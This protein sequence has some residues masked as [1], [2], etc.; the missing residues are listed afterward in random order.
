VRYSDDEVAALYDVLNPWGPGDD[1]YLALV[2]E[3]ASVLDVGCGTGAL[4]DRARQAGHSGR[5]VGLDPDPAMLAVAR[6][7]RGDVEWVAGTAAS[8]PWEREFDLAIMM[9]HAFQ[10]LVGDEELRASLAAI[11]RALTGGGRFMFETRNPLARAWEGWHPGEAVEVVDPAGRRV[12]VWHEVE[13]AAGDVVTV[14]ETTGDPD[15]V[16]WRVDRGRLRFLDAGTLTGFLAEAGFTIEARY[17]GWSREP[18][19][20]ASPEIIT[21]ARR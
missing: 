8:M 14:T 1:F 21:V 5:L 13:S 4:L 16:P 11:R 15:G 12:R 17:G 3:A 6:R 19:G 9:G 2:M 20:P 7:R 18:L 10:E